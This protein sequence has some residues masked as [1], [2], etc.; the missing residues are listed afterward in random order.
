M[1]AIIYQELYGFYTA[2]RGEIFFFLMIQIITLHHLNIEDYPKICN[3]S[4]DVFLL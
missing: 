2:P 4:M 1:Y 3:Y